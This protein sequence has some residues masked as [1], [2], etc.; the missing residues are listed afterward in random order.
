[1][2]AIFLEGETGTKGGKKEKE[3]GNRRQTTHLTASGHQGNIFDLLYF[4]N[5]DCSGTT[6]GKKH[7]VHKIL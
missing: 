1:M 4:S 6:T 5:V 2:T 7:T 3:T